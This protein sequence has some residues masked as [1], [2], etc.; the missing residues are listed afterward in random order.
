MTRTNKT[1]SELTK[2]LK[3]YPQITENVTIKSNFDLIKSKDIALV[4]SEVEAKLMGCGR[5]ILRPSGT[6]PV[7]RIS[8]EGEDYDLI[9][10]SQSSLLIKLS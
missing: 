6:E 8:V 10:N 5:V 2:N 9:V 4:V 1:L 7:V 3:K